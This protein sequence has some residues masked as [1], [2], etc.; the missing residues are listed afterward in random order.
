MRQLPSG[1]TAGMDEI[2]GKRPY[3]SG[4]SLSQ[5]AWKQV[6][7]GR[8]LV[9]KEFMTPIPQL[10]WLELQKHRGRIWKTSVEALLSATNTGATKV[11][12]MA[13]YWAV[14]ALRPAKKGTASNSL[15][16]RYF[17]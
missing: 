14:K 13:Y 1:Q 17:V 4:E 7:Q 2:Q 12:I 6:A 8:G 5:I 3:R 11:L 15:P 10:C 16:R 9:S